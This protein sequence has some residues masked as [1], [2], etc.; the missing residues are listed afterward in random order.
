MLSHQPRAG[1]ALLSRISTAGNECRELRSLAAWNLD[2]TVE[3]LA[4]AEKREGIEE[5]R[6]LDSPLLSRFERGQ[7]TLSPRRVKLL[8]RVLRAE[9]GRR[10]LALAQVIADWPKTGRASA[11]A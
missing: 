6:R 8:K 10:H 2:E 3:E 5:S 9:I 1:R 4:R 11:L 7:I